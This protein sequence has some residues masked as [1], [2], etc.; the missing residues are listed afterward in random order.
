MLGAWLLRFPIL[1]AVVLSEY[2]FLS[3]LDDE[4]SFVRFSSIGFNTRYRVLYVK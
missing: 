2:R 3:F 4:Y 1:H